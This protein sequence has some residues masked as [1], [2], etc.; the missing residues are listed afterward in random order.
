M[1]PAEQMAGY[2]TDLDGNIVRSS[3]AT[4]ESS[5]FGDMTVDGATF[6]SVAAGQYFDL[7]GSAVSNDFTFG[8][9]ADG[10]YTRIEV[11][12]PFPNP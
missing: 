5:D 12:G 9:V 4:S 2:V 3:Y 11:V 1:I 10:L 6:I 7:A 8:G